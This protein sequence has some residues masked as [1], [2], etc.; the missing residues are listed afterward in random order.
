MAAKGCDMMLLDLVIKL[1]DAGVV[2]NVT[3]GASA[4]YDSQIV[5]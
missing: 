4:L 3:T 1:V 5:L 2:Q